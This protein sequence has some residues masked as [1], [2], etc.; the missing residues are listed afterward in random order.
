MRLSLQ[1]FFDASWV[2]FTAFGG[3]MV[4]LSNVI[5]ALAASLYLM[6][7][8]SLLSFLLWN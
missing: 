8:V 6:F 4:S 7:V 5:N 1:H 2:N 3:W